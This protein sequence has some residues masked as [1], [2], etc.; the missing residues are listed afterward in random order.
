M[1]FSKQVTYGEG[2]WRAEI[3]T[4]DDDA[5]GY[6]DRARIGFWYGSRAECEAVDP[7]KVT[8]YPMQPEEGIDQF[9]L[10]CERRYD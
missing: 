2:G 7:S 8:L 1:K 4:D 5:S 6:G 3:Y 9:D 10:A